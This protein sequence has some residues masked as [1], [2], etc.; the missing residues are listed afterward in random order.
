MLKRQKGS[1]LVEFAVVLPILVLLLLGGIDL[2]E[3]SSTNSSLG[4]IA[5]ETSRCIALNSA[6]C[7]SGAAP[8]AQQLARNLGMNANY[9]TVPQ[10]TCGGTPDNCLVTVS[11]QYHSLFHVFPATISMTKTFQSTAP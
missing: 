5:E 6:L 11:Y 2:I 1:A 7:A 4:Y 10:V 3:A 8:Y 9:L